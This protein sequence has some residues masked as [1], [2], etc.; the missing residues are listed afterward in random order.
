[1]STGKSWLEGS[2]QANGGPAAT[3]ATTAPNANGTHM[4]R[5]SCGIGRIYCNMLPKRSW[6]LAS[7]RIVRQGIVTVLTIARSN[8]EPITLI[9]AVVRRSLLR[10]SNM[11]TNRFR[12][13]HLVPDKIR[14]INHVEA[15]SGVSSVPKSS[16]SRHKS[17]DPA[18]LPA[19]LFGT[20]DHPGVLP[21]QYELKE[22]AAGGRS[23]KKQSPC[24][25]FYISSRNLPS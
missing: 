16:P 1:M 4:T 14:K 11:K 13:R 18:R 19:H 24:H 2:V 20:P 8:T 9:R 6:P 17:I 21:A 22:H 7:S 25:L 12:G 5:P 15:I 3:I 10:W 23:Q